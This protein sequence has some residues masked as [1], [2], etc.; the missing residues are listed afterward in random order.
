MDSFHLLAGVNHAAGN[1]CVQST[2]KF[3][4]HFSIVH[5]NVLSVTIQYWGSQPSLACNVLQIESLG[6]RQ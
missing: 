6:R 5:Y 3:S 4:G 2:V 1:L